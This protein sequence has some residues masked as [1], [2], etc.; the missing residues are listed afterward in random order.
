M[1]KLQI[2]SLLYALLNLCYFMGPVYFFYL[3]LSLQAQIFFMKQGGLIPLQA[4]M[5]KGVT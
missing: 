4:Q 5:I 2:E 3:S 1:M